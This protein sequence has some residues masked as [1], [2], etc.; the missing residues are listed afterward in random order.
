MGGDCLD[1]DNTVEGAVP[2]VGPNGEIYVAWALGDDIWFDHSTDGGKTWQKE[3]LKAVTGTKGWD[4]TIPGI[5]RAN[6][7]PITKC[8]L[9]EGPHRGTIYINW[10]DQRAGEDDTDIW[11][12]RSEDGGLSWTEPLRVNDDAPGRHQFFSWMDID[13]TTG[14]LYVVYYDRRN[15]E[16][17]G[18]DVYLAVSKDGGKTFTNTQISKEPFHPSD[19]I[20]FGDYNNISALWRLRQTDL[21][22]PGKRQHLEHPHRPHQPRISNLSKGFHYL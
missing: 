20:F 5:M 15:H 19:K 22:A 12:A 17:V 3:D 9:S 16:D 14:Y 13:P 8:D 7:L 18:T 6:G 1:E 2:A 10:S 21:D 11:L 4:I